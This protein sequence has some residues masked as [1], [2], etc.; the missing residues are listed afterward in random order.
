MISPLSSLSKR[1][2]YDE[3]DP[4]LPS[5]DPNVERVANDDEVHPNSQKKKTAKAEC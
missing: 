5:I 1:K 2:K 4:L 3:S